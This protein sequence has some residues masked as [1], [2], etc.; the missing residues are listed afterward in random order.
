MSIENIGS[1]S[2]LAQA[3]R[4]I[5]FLGNSGLGVGFFGVKS[6]GTVVKGKKTFFTPIVTFDSTLYTEVNGINPPWNFVVFL[7]GKLA[8]W[9]QL[10]R[11]MPI[12][13]PKTTIAFS[14]Y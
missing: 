12:R 10:S 7:S 13:N 5:R 3:H 8:A 9:R 1:C 6:T 4:A 14:V 11:R 2:S